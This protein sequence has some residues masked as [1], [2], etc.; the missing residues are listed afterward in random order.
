[1]NAN[2]LDRFLAA[3]PKAEL[4]LHLEGSIEPDI[5][6][7]LARRHGV[8]LTPEEVAARY[9]YH[10]FA[11][12]LEAF[13]WVTSFLR[14]PADYGLITARLIEQLASQNVVYAEVT[15]S[16][17]VML[18]RHQDVEAN[19]AAIHE[20]GGRARAQGVRLQWIFDAVRQFGP[21]AAMEVA[22]WAG[23]MRPGGVVAFGMGGDEL[24]L[25]T[26]D[27]RPVYDYAAGQGLHRLVHAGEVGRPEAVREAVELLGA[28]R[29]GH[30]IAAMRQ[31]QAI[32]FLAARQVP[33]E[34]CP[35]SNLSTGALAC[36]LG[37]RKA[38][39]E[40]HP[41]RQFFARGLGVTLASD[42]PAMFHTTLLGEY[43]LGPRLGLDRGALVRIAE[44]GFEFAFLL[45]GEKR[46]LLEALRA[47]T[48]SPG[49][50]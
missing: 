11:D 21:G 45:P 13:K 29:I 41:L 50:V 3:L 16:V 39:I 9:A 32:E 38:R 47:R 2:D 5:A 31:E 44:M 37:R 30:G 8:R 34:I 19:F 6:V 42:D 12:F 22:R 28:E 49:L 26:A 35:T 24:G 33:L 23:R 48:N 4:H 10:D 18:R 27:F 20:A 15:V 25:P 14:T 7:E 17:G 1:M 40:D 36:Q 43:A 46:A